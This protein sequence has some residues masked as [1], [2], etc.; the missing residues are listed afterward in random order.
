[1]ILIDVSNDSKSEYKAKYGAWRLAS[2]E[3]ILKVKDLYLDLKALEEV[4]YRKVCFTHLLSDGADL[5][6][7]PR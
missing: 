3:E 7:V 5:L 2:E 6:L 4:L 1:M